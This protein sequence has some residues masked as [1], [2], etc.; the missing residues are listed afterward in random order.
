MTRLVFP[1]AERPAVKAKGTVSPSE[2]PIVASAMS[3]A[4]ILKPFFPLSGLCCASRSVFK[5]HLL[6][7]LASQIDRRLADRRGRRGSLLKPRGPSLLGPFET[8]VMVLGKKKCLIPTRDMAL[9]G[10]DVVCK[11][12][13]C[14]P[15]GVSDID[16]LI[17][18]AY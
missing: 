5:L 12:G 17:V 15:F 9:V 6:L 2:R 4:S 1:R 11:G 8:E 16:C 14:A 13:C 18:D 3:L 7:C 10:C